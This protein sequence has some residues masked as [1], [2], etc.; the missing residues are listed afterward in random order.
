[1]ENKKK[2]LVIG[3][4]SGNSALML[5]AIK[6]KYGDDIILYTPQEAKKEGLTMNDF[7]NIPSY[8]LTAP[9]LIAHPTIIGTNKSGQENRRQRRKNKRKKP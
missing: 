4:G 9:K 1:M 2:I 6:E 8:K 5:Q 3:S 7:D